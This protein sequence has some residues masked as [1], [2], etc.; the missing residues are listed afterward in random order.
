MSKHHSKRNPKES[1][2]TPCL[3]GSGRSSNVGD[4]DANI[5]T[6]FVAWGTADEEP[7]TRK[8][9]KNAV[10]EMK[11]K[12]FKH[13]GPEMKIGRKHHLVKGTDSEECDGKVEFEK[14]EEVAHDFYSKITPKP[15]K[16]SVHLHESNHKKRCRTSDRPNYDFDSSIAIQHTAASNMLSDFREFKNSHCTNKE[17]LPVSNS[18]STDSEDDYYNSSKRFSSKTP[19]LSVNEHDY[20]HHQQKMKSDR[21]HNQTSITSRDRKH[22]HYR[23]RSHKDVM[24]QSRF[25]LGNKRK[26]N[27]ARRNEFDDS[28]HS[29]I[30]D[31]FS[32]SF[33]T[34]NHKNKETRRFSEGVYY[35]KHRVRDSFDTSLRRSTSST[36]GTCVF[37]KELKSPIYKT[38]DDKRLKSARNVLIYEM[39]SDIPFIDTHC[40]VDFLFKRIS[41]YQSFTEYMDEAFFQF[42][43][44]FEGMIADWCQ[45]SLYSRARPVLTLNDPNVSVWGAFGCHPHHVETYTEAVEKE[46]EFHIDTYENVIAW[47][48]MGLDYSDRFGPTDHELQKKVFI[49][50][51]KQACRRQYPLVIHC[52]DAD[53]DL[54][55]IM[56][57]HVPHDYKIHRHCL[58]T[59]YVFLM[60]FGTK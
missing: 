21:K 48:E 27:F 38:F 7:A 4:F 10:V 42:P 33:S 8:D 26:H 35:T 46:V 44:N 25:E 31:K 39:N 30:S 16:I 60:H 41:Y 50:Q 34:Y 36:R 51:L 23:S 12:I 11:N 22:H 56:K 6:A 2:S 57:R 49:R 3:H 14:R 55:E 20:Q 5:S 9:K 18:E 43:S 28:R 53:P 13:L 15:A 32:Q 58:T 45:P 47:G 19:R 17:I 54:L 52:R 29:E 37:E 1:I 59:E 24:P 40:H